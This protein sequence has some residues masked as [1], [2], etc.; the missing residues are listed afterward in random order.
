M[1]EIDVEGEVGRVRKALGDIALM[2]VG[3]VRRAT[4]GAIEVRLRSERCDDREVIAVH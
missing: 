4:L 1:T 3:D 2:V